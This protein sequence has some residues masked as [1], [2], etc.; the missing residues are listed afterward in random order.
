[1][2]L[3]ESDSQLEVGET[4]PGFELQDP[5]EETVELS[6]LDN[7]DGVLVVFMC[8]HCPFVKANLPELSR[9]ID[10]FPSVAFVGVNPNSDVHPQDTVEKMPELMD[11]YDLEAENFYYLADPDQEVAESYGATCTPDPFLL[12]MR[13]R[14]FYQGRI[15][16]K[17]SPSDELTNHEMQGVIQDMLKSRDPLEEQNPSQGCSIKWK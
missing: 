2:S 7:Y 14:L 8:N 4:A 16:D 9:L 10:K 15:S 13:H 17:T 6:D 11:E 1:M 3:L 12:D 5:E